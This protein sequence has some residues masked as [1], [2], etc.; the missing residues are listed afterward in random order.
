MG[1][2][3]GLEFPCWALPADA[4][5][6]RLL[7]IYGQRQEG[8]LMQRVKV[9]GGRIGASGLRALALAAQKFT[10]GYSLHLTTRQD[11]EFHGVTAEALPPLQAALAAAGLTG[12]GACGD[13]LRNVTVCAGCGVAGDSWDLS[14][15]ADSIRQTAEALPFIR[16]MPRKFK[17]SLS[18]CPKACARPWINDLGL[19]ALPSGKFEVILAGSLGARPNTGLK[20]YDDLDPAE[21]LPLVVA[22]LGLFNREGDRTNRSR[23]RFR[24]VR[25]RMGDGAFLSEVDRLFTEEKASVKYAAPVVTRTDAALALVGHLRPPLGDIPPETALALADFLDQ[26][27]GIARIGLEHD[28]LIFAA[29]GAVLRTPL[30]QLTRGPSVVA[31][32]GNISCAHGIAD[33]TGVAAAL[34]AD[35]ASDCLRTAISGCPNNC[36]H[37]AVADIGLVGRLKTL[38]GVKRE[39]FRLLA[40]GGNGATDGLGIELHPA[41]PAPDVP[42]ARRIVSGEYEE[43]GGA[44]VSFAGFVS[45]EEER[46]RAL[47]AEKF[48]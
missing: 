6:A 33:S 46:L 26:N 14:A 35:G 2:L 3:H 42:A 17:I 13:T 10:P 19:V 31:C 38:D 34:V 25:E 18:G 23:A 11:V 39:C 5:A 7:G 4:N 30:D 20:A 16:T 40:G 1:D 32:P 37:A 43:N 9:P 47:L 8:L 41:V 48:D 21:V 36:S 45:A 12:M 27:G 15:L 29:A 22:A 28:I 24:H 44:S